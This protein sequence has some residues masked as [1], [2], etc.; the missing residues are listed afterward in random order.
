MKKVMVINRASCSIS[1]NLPELM[2]SRVFRSFG[3]P[4]DR[5]EIA[6]SE[7]KAL[8]YTAGGRILLD[9]YLMIDDAD[10][11]EDLGITTEPEYFYTEDELVALLK[12]GTMDQLLDCLQF[13]PEGVLDLLKKVAVDIRLDSTEKR[14]VIGEH[15]KVNLDAM[16]KNDIIIKQAESAAGKEE[17][18]KPAGR[19]S[20]PVS[21]TR[22]AAPVKAD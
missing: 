1:Y 15:L 16:I 10:V 7:L 4:G 2:A 9:S 3:T 21:T 22:K 13:A 6:D 18:A 5:M 19:R 8:S 11:T 20:K 12:K 17:D 14:K